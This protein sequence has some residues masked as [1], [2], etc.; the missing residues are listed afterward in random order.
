MAFLLRVKTVSYSPQVDVT[1][2]DAIGDVVDCHPRP[3]TDRCHQSDKIHGCRHEEE[4]NGRLE[5][6]DVTVMEY[7][8]GVRSLSDVLYNIRDLLETRLRAD[9]RLRRE[10][11]W[12]QQTMHEWM[13][14]AAVI[15]RV[16]FIVF[17]LCFLVG[18]VVMFV[19]AMFVHR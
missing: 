12:K 8:N 11:D 6:C 18:T 2:N 13:F 5:N 16:C 4:G 9:D 14:A 19:V 7:G 3:V 15:D 1:R 10:S 17:S